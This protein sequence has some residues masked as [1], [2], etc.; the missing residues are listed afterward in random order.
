[1]QSKYYHTSRNCVEFYVE[2]GAVLLAKSIIVRFIITVIAARIR[3]HNSRLFLLG[4]A[5]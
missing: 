3:A 5:M 2:C 4:T 1:M